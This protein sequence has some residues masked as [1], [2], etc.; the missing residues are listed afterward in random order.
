MPD[1]Q[2]RLHYILVKLNSSIIML[3]KEEDPKERTALRQQAA[4]Y[5]TIYS[6]ISR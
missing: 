3:M 2:E 5:A 1:D 6:A 4:E